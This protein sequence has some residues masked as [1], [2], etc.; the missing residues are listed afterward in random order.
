MSLR[1]NVL[2]LALAALLLSA[3]TANRFGNVANQCSDRAAGWGL[4]AAPPANSLELLALESAGRPV[5]EQLNAGIPLREVWFSQG[6]D[7]LM[8]CRY[9]AGADV[10]PV[11]I[12]ADFTL[13]AHGWSAGPVES[14]ICAE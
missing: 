6:S 7:R 10:C 3:C 1:N 12:T 13:T 4:A 9:E 14:R 8:V 2:V 11:A 5:R